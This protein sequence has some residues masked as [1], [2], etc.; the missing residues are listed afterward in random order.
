MPRVAEPTPLTG[1]LAELSTAADFFAGEREAHNLEVVRF[2][3]GPR[4]FSVW[5]GN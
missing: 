3:S 5:L 1:G 4:N 2:E